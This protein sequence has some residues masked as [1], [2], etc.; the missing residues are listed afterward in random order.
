VI[1]VLLIIPFYTYDLFAVKSQDCPKYCDGCCVTTKP[2]NATGLGNIAPE[3]AKSTSKGVIQSSITG[4][5]QKSMMRD[6]GP[7]PPQCPPKGPIPLDCTKKPF[8]N[9]TLAFR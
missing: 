3:G 7:T 9:A 4:D 8:P 1:A 5:N 2:K 6:N